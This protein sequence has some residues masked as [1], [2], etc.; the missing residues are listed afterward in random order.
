MYEAIFTIDDSDES[1]YTNSTKNTDCDL[2]LWCN[3]HSDILFVQG[4]AIESI[5][6]HIRSDIGIAEKT[7]NDESV[8]LITKSCLIDTKENYIG[9]YIDRHGCMLLP[10]RRYNKEGKHCRILALDPD[11]LSGLYRDLIDD[12]YDVEINSKKQID[13]PSKPTPLLTTNI[14]SPELTTRQYNVLLLAVES[15]YYE[16]PKGTT[17]EELAS[18]LDIARRTFDQHLRI[19]E[20]KVIASFVLSHTT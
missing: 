15:G 7:V 10:P 6:P 2:E 5:L 18:K 9:D 16:I 14:G 3:G 1:V 11:D 20:K 12:G 19:A 13:Q 17:T 8:I 4:T